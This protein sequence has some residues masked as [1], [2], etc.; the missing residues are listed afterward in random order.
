ML[1]VVFSACNH[2]SSQSVP[3]ANQL[4]EKLQPI[5]S[6]TTMDNTEP[7]QN[8][9][10][11][12]RDEVLGNMIVKGKL[13]LSAK[14]GQPMVAG[15]FVPKEAI[16]DGEGSWKIAAKKLTFKEVEIKGLVTRHWCGPHEQCPSKGFMDRMTDVEYFKEL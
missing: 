15:I 13:T 16:V 14:G 8:G 1:T 10:Q 2:R 12:G 7:V 3:E 9:G 11:E 6:E 5:T 4:P